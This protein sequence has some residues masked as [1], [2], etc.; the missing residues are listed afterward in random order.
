MKTI[1]GHLSI[2]VPSPQNHSWVFFLM[3]AVWHILCLHTDSSP[4]I[5]DIPTLALV[6]FQ[7]ICRVDLS[8]RQSSL[9]DHFY[10]AFFTVKLHFFFLIP[11]NEGMVKTM[12]DFKLF[13]FHL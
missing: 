5:N 8:L 2:G 4:L 7:E 1:A 13:I 12:S 9:H 10:S 11:E 3:D 6:R